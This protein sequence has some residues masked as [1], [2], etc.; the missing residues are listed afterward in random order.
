MIVALENEKVRK[1]F[2][3]R[4]R[5]YLNNDHSVIILDKIEDFA[6]MMRTIEDI[7]R[8][9]A[10]LP[11][12]E[13]VDKLDKMGIKKNVYSMSDR[14]EFLEHMEFFAGK[15]VL[16]YIEMHLNDHCNLNC[17]GCGHLSNIAPVKFADYDQFAKDIYKLKEL[18][19]HINKFRLM[20]GEP[21]LN[22]N[23]TE[24]AELVRSENRETDI[25]IVTNGLNFG[26]NSAYTLKRLAELDI[27]LDISSY[28]PTIERKEYIAA[29]LDQFGVV[30][31][32]SENID[33]FLKF[34]N[35]DF[36]K[37]IH[38]SHE[39]CHMK[40]GTFLREGKMAAC[41]FPVIYSQIDTFMKG[42]FAVDSDIINIYDSDIN[43]WKVAWRLTHPL[44]SCRYCRTDRPEF[45]AWESRQKSE[46]LCEDWFVEE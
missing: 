3:D 26:S 39:H 15:P 22:P 34:R 18:F 13:D 29:S 20:G 30:Y 23:L 43:G 4:I 41:S 21:F 27:Q 42:K 19:G 10:V 12:V 25:R 9:A 31:H 16:P 11:T 24:F 8:V 35:P 36:N 2:C 32:F 44:N 5:D 46:A 37:D 28:P 7:S 40:M 45:Y 17:K 14:E 38:F 6:K 1:L 33:T